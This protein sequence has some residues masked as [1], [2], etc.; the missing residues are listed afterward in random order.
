MKVSTIEKQYH[1]PFKTL[2]LIDIIKMFMNLFFSL[3]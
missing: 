2:V 3:E 1:Q